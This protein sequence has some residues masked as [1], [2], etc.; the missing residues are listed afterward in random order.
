MAH[1]PPIVRLLAW[2][3]TLTYILDEARKRRPH[4]TPTPTVGDVTNRYFTPDDKKETGQ[5]EKSYAKLRNQFAKALSSHV[6]GMESGVLN[7][8][9]FAATTRRYIRKYYRAA[10]EIGKKITADNPTL[11][12]NDV[13]AI[14]GEA[15][16]EIPYAEKFADDLEAGDGV[17][18]YESR[19]G[20]YT[21]ALDS[22][23]TLGQVA[24]L[25]PKTIIHYRLSPAEHCSDCVEWAAN[26]PYTPET[27]PAVP[28]DGTS[29]CKSNCKCYL[30]IDFPE[31][32]ETPDRSTKPPRK[33][34]PPRRDDPDAGPGG[35]DPDDFGPEDEPDLSPAAYPHPDD[36]PAA[37]IPTH[38]EFG[39]EVTDEVADSIEDL[40]A[41]INYY[42]QRAELAP[43]EERS[44]WFALRKQANADLIALEKETGVYSVPT[45]SVKELVQS[46]TSAPPESHVTAP[47]QIQKGQ[48]IALMKGRSVWRAKVIKIDPDTK[49]FRAKTFDGDEVEFRVGE[50]PYLVWDA[51]DIDFDGDGEAE[52]FEIVEPGILPNMSGPPAAPSKKTKKQ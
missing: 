47:A 49:T 24:G 10:Y 44:E 40:R 11:S 48:S 2:R 38:D 32:V 18:D 36:A 13:K 26:S 45:W 15:D 7:S 29:Q 42:R 33:G 9:D 5:L 25:D 41:K 3:S 12:D 37:S 23:F 51:P 52:D 21:K 30:D 1:A 50:P 20:L 16:D 31:E 22:L 14:D 28:R 8:A 46:A 35:F 27:L 17:M 4:G 6:G 39:D 19:A 43:P 34:Q